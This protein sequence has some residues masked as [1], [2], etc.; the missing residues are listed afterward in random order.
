M[1]SLFLIFALM[2]PLWGLAQDSCLKDCVLNSECGMGGICS[3]GKCSYQSAYCNDERWSVNSRGE[4]RDCREYRCDKG[5]GT[6]LNKANSSQDCLFGYVFDG[7]Q[8]CTSSVQ[9]NSAD[10]NCQALIDRWNAAR[11]Q[12]ENSLPE[13]KPPTY[14][15]VSCKLDS[16]CSSSQICWSNRCVD[17]LPYCRTESDGH[18]SQISNN[19]ILGC[20]QFACDYV[21]GQCLSS[22]NSDKD[23]ISSS[24]CQNRLCQ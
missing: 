5:S 7:S 4:T 1:K 8:T 10:P 19:Q 20:G 21:L 16:E 14:S 17:N 18:F 11:T 12:Y 3:N 22:C 9:C 13:P 6:C 15:C 24:K 23:C 2:F